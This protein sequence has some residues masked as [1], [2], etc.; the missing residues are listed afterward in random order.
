MQIAMTAH[1]FLHG[2]KA[3]GIFSVV[4]KNTDAFENVPLA[5]LRNVPETLR[6]LLQ[7]YFD[8]DYS[9]WNKVAKQDRSGREAC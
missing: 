6:D 2:R 9:K 4:A 5:K 8:H 3:G 1:N 7:V